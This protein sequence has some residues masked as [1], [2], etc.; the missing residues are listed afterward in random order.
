VTLLF[1]YLALALAVSFLCS[2]LEAVLLSIQPTYVAALSS[3]RPRV[4]ELLAR[5]KSDIDRPLAAILILNTISH[6]VGAAGVGAQAVK[7]F[8]SSSVGWVSAILTLL[9]LVISE[10]IPKTLGASYWRQLAPLSARILAV[11]ILLLYPLVVVSR[12][13]SSLLAREKNEPTV[14]RAELTALADVVASEGVV[15]EVESRVLR[16]LLRLRSLR[17]RDIMTPRNVLVAFDA[18]TTVGAAI[19]DDRQRQFSRLPIYEGTVDNITGYVLKHDIMLEAAHDHDEVTLGELSREVVSM[20]ET[21]RLPEV[22]EEM[23]RRKEHI[24]VLHEELGGTAGITTLEDVVETLLGL[25]I[26]DETDVTVDMRE[27]ARQNW[28]RRARERGLLTEPEK[29]SKP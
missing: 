19:H 8:G 15:D 2:L 21:A 7:V 23:L 6:T 1:F 13:L 14:S 22:L 11:M 20:P 17:A 12:A 25:E 9:I 18:K 27:L 5:L 3:E 10:I 28:E 16:N 26:V 24:V 29:G 4:G